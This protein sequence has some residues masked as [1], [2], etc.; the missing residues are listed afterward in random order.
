MEIINCKICLT[1]NTRPRVKFDE[2]KICNACKY[3]DKKDIN[4]AKRTDELR[5]ICNKYRSKTNEYDCIVPWSGGK[6]SSSVTYKLKF[7]YGMNPLLVTFHLIP[8]KVGVR[9]RKIF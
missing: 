6:D 8:W 1:P 9:N 2:N 7:D 4:W 5:D 3:K